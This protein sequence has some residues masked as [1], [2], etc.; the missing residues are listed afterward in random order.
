MDEV[1][2][3]MHGGLIHAA[4]AVPEGLVPF[5]LN[6]LGY[7]GMLAALSWPRLRAHERL[8]FRDWAG[9]GEA[10]NPLAPKAR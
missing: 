3:K 7:L 5:Y 10:G 8:I 9:D 1:L 4:W 2:P 6:A